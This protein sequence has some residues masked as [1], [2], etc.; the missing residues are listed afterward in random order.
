MGLKYRY[1]GTQSFKADDANVFFGRDKDVR[2]LLRMIRLEQIVVMY[3]KSGLGK[4]SLLNAGIIPALG[5][6]ISIGESGNLLRKE[7][8]FETV[9]IRFGSYSE[10]LHSNPTQI[11]K[12]LIWNKESLHPL[13][14]E[15]DGTKDSLWYSLMSKQLSGKSSEYGT[16]LIFDQFEE[17]FSYPVDQVGLFQN[18]FSAVLNSIMPAD[19]RDYITKKCRNKE[20]KVT[21]EQRRQI[22]RPLK[23]KVLISIRSDRLSLM[24]Q[25]AT[26]QPNI[27]VNLYELGSLKREHARHAIVFPAQLKNEDFISPQFDYDEKAIN[28]ILNLLS[29]ENQ[30]IESF[31][32]QLICQFLEKRVLREDGLTQIKSVHLGGV[33]GMKNILSNYYENALADLSDEERLIA[34]R[35]IEEGLISNKK[36]V[37]LA[38]GS[39]ERLF[40]INQDLV[41]RLI[42]S[43]LLRSTNI[44]LGKIYELSHD[45]LVD[46]ILRSY[47]I[48]KAKEEK[49]RTEEAL[50]KQRKQLALE[51]SR[52]RR[53]I[54]LAIAGFTL[55]IIALG[56]VWVA[57]KSSTEARENELKANA[58]SLASQAW[59]IFQFD[60]TS[61]LRVAEA[62][63]HIDPTNKSVEQILT[64]I[65]KM[66]NLSIFKDIYDDHN[67]EITDIDISP[68]S[69]KWASCSHDKSIAIH[70]YVSGDLDTIL[71]EHQKRIN[72]I[73]FSPNAELLVSGG[74]GEL[75]LWNLQEDTLLKLNVS[76]QEDIWD[77]AFA[78][79]GNWFV[80]T[81]RN[82]VKIWSSEGDLIKEF[83]NSEDGLN[84][85]A[86]SRD[87]KMIMTGSLD[88]NVIVRD[89][90]AQIIRSFENPNVTITSVAF[91]PNGK[92]IIYSGSHKIAEIREIYGNERV[93]FKGHEGE[94]TDISI[95]SDGQY[96]VTASEDATAKLWNAN[97]SELASFVGGKK[98]L[99]CTAISPDGNIALSGGFDF[100][101]KSWDIEFN[102]ELTQN[103]HKDFIYSLDVS[104][105]NAKI[106]TG[107]KDRTAKIWNFN[108]ELLADLLGH[109]NLIRTA[110]FIPNSHDV[111][112]ASQDQQVRIWN[113]EG[114]ALLI[115]EMDN[116]VNYAIASENRSR[117]VTGDT[118]GVIAIFSK[119]GKLIHSW[120]GSKNN[121]P[122]TSLQFSS[123]N[124]SILSSSY[125]QTV[126]IWSLDG[127]LMDSVANDKRIYRTAFAG[128]DQ[129][130]LTV[131]NEYTVEKWSLEYDTL[132]SFFGHTGENYWINVDPSN[133]YIAT[134]S[135]DKTA[136]I[137][138]MDGNSVLTIPH[139]N[140]VY[141][142]V[143]S[144]D[145]KY[146]ITGSH[147]NIG[148]IWNMKGEHITSLG[149]RMPYQ[150]I[151]I[152]E[153]VPNLFEIDFEAVV[154]E[155][156][157][158][159]VL[160][161]FSKNVD[162]I[163][164]AGKFKYDQA[165]A[166]KSNYDLSQELFD[167][168]ISYFNAVSK[169]PISDTLSHDRLEYLA[170]T[171]K[172]KGE[173]QFINRE[174][175][176]ANKSFTSGLKIIKTDYLQI[177]DILSDIYSDQLVQAK[178][179]AIPL[180]EI[181]TED[182]SYYDNFRQALAEEIGWFETQHGLFHK[183]N[184]L[185]REFLVNYK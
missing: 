76:S 96:I 74:L 111:I 30:E 161:I 20:G 25:F 45:T 93:T 14:E 106:V 168:A 175:E 18:Q 38:A 140:N 123:E 55:F 68:N 50:E 103:P 180:L 148:R 131:A 49:I 139:E 158:K 21:P 95:S 173:L 36:R 34:Q 77:L 31:Q 79:D 134:A 7:F 144:K 152:D 102:K 88:G 40:G 1:P 91:L 151:T 70:D 4:T 80:T 132:Q 63:Y 57:M 24:D 83:L 41:E 81:S 32:L 86:I 98:R 145:S 82:I 166:K 6:E 59:G 114:K 65:V 67:F 121:E 116:P 13:I 92:E 48:R 72:A 153:R 78:L 16:V 130:I 99:N 177:L 165:V 185:F 155:L 84:A 9:E 137:W 71:T 174:F 109:T 128:N 23:T 171:Y 104:F 42:E 97:G 3:G 179:K 164:E 62:A 73:A 37:A 184:D 117:I 159:E 120:Q 5:G 169:S 53:A 135:W 46:P 105:D 126:K 115:I 122:I 182:I 47:E 170:M 138:D 51:S 28:E 156:T 129:H 69:A 124:E 39:E 167:E 43:R 146:L 12:K 10:D 147:D 133:T 172:E 112:T 113:E 100:D 101:I 149:E 85:V 60:H 35:F 142:A 110:F 56:A 119:E 54:L 127:R 163:H 26:S 58:A 61:A 183:D 15:F 154:E 107:S 94:V 157:T 33:E 8:M 66:P 52:K 118:K 125:D 162:L 143:F 89:F 136:R 141:A 27:L 178:N 75:F 19:F 22:F 181:P 90:N 17:L 64:N 29:D 160:A 150:K 87:N 108:G 176:K 2:R 44:H 11:L